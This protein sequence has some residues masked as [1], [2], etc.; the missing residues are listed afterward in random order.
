MLDD[1]QQGSHHLKIT[2]NVSTGLTYEEV[3]RVVDPVFIASTGN[4]FSVYIEDPKTM[5]MITLQFSSRALAEN[6]PDDDAVLIGAS[7][8]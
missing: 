6:Q 3:C 8:Y 2:E 7:I 1:D 4:G 5:R